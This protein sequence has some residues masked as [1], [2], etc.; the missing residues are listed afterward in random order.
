MSR[1]APTGDPTAPAA[2]VVGTLTANYSASAEA[3]EQLWAAA[4]LPATVQLLDR[5]PLPAAQRILDLGAGVGTLLPRLRAKAPR[6]AIVAADRAEGMLRRAEPAWPR[7]VADAARLPFPAGRFDIVV[8]AFMLFHVPDPVAALREAHRVLCPGGVLGLTTWAST[9]DPP[10]ARIWDA[11]L[12]RY[13]AAPVAPLFAQH[14][15]MDSCEK[16]RGLLAAAGFV[17]PTTE[18]VP[19]SHTPSPEAFIAR[20]LTMGARGRRLAGLPSTAQAAFAQT[21]RRRLTGLEPAGFV[22]R[23]EVILA[24]ATTS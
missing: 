22:E 10:A 16:V 5:L 19:W 13:G 9:V 7:V 24:S 3:Y 4:L 2:D 11:E 12:D 21:V 1:A 20:L 18:Q 6:A 23:G 17:D 15:L 14:H 8:M